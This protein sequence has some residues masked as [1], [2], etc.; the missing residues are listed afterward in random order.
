M[1]AS[2]ACRAPSRTAA[3]YSRRRPPF[4]WAGCWSLAVLLCTLVEGSADNVVFRCLAHLRCVGALAIAGALERINPDQLGWWLCE[5]Q[6]A[7]GGLNGRPEKLP[8]VCYSWWVLSSLAMVGR[9][10]W[11]DR[12]QLRN[13][14][15]NAQDEV[16]GG[17]A[18]RCAMLPANC[19]LGRDGREAY[20]HPIRKVRVISPLR[21]LA[22]A[23]RGNSR[24]PG[25]VADVFHTFFGICGL[26]LL[27][28][29]E[30]DEGG[31]TGLKKVDP[32]YALPVITLKR[33]GLPVWRE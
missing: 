11:I 22:D 8:D 14:I 16:A 20:A 9:I 33:M 21:W 13:F 4:R 10:D 3:R 25:D 2:A 5:R 1:E 31:Y 27:G 18:D 15:L 26:S 24:R 17:I 7:G 12:G 28:Y 23:V 30:E 19:M 32:V 6:V 29:T